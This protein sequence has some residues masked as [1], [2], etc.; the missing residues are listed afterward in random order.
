MDLLRSVKDQTDDAGAVAQN[1]DDEDQVF[2][3]D[4]YGNMLTSFNGDV[5]TTL[6]YTGEQFNRTTGQY[7]L[8]ARYYD[9]A[10]GRFNRLDAFA[11]NN[12]DPISLHKYLYAG[13]NP[14]MYSDPTGM[15]SL[16]GMLRNIGVLASLA[17]MNNLA[18][19]LMSSYKIGS[20]GASWDRLIANLS[21][22]GAAYGWGGAG[23]ISAYYD[24]KTQGVHVL[25]TGEG[26][27]VPLSR[28]STPQCRGVNWLFSFGMIWNADDGVADLTGASATAV[29]PACMMTWVTPS[30]IKT[31][32]YWGVMMNLAKAAKNT[33][34]A[35]QGSYMISNSW[36]GAVETSYGIGSYSFAAIYGGTV[37]VPIGAIFSKF[38][39]VVGETISEVRDAF[40]SFGSQAL[41]TSEGSVNLIRRVEGIL[42]E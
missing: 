13:A 35:R 1:G 19:S 17:T 5:L 15:F 42:Y 26:G 12:Q 10:T 18:V 2:D 22:G 39:S 31:S 14:V 30:P 27:L 6:L 7:Y 23:T 40:R 29:W 24:F 8:R 20:G 25:F 28:F 16:V 34:K 36:G 37:E 11:G 33:P 9:P 32:S 41:T 3:Y 38:G 4:A 21:I